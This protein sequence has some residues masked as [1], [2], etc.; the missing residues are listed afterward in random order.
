[1][2]WWKLDINKNP[3]V[4]SHYNFKSE[5]M[6]Q[7]SIK[8][9]YICI[10]LL[11]SVFQLSHCPL[12]QTRVQTKSKLSDNKS[13]WQPTVHTAITSTVNGAAI[14]RIDGS[15][16]TGRRLQLEHLSQTPGYVPTPHPPLMYACPLLSLDAHGSYL[17]LSG[18]SGMLHCHN[19][20]LSD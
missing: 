1:M 17:S 18:S 16:T 12:N 4:W 20:S 11:K 3:R 9:I 14:G 15:K 8:T 10:F 5:K 7:N 19:D 2:H 6:Q 13:S